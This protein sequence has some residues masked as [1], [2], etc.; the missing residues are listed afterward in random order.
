MFQVVREWDPM[1]A[2]VEATIRAA[3]RR[4]H[5]A[6]LEL[7]P[8]YL[9]ADIEEGQVN[10]GASIR[11]AEDG[12]FSVCYLDRP[13]ES[14]IEQATGIRPERTDLAEVGSLAA[15]HPGGV[16]DLIF[17]IVEHLRAQGIR[18]AFFTATA[19]LRTLLSRSGIPL[20]EL[21]AASPARIADARSWGSFYE[22][23]PRV[24]AVG[25]AMLFSAPH[26]VFPCA[27]A[28]HHA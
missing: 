12:F 6:R 2:A 18:W 9:V 11:F 19:R 7:L 16:R 26:L 23:D 22:N 14:L 25:D 20:I 24:M 28:V 21:A 15:G 4:E 17:A 10:G 1:R 8:R 5:G 27:G 13:I 3:Y